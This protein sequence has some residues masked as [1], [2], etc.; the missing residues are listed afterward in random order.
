[1]RGVVAVNPYDYDCGRGL[2]RSSVLANLFIGMSGLPLISGAI[3]RV[4]PYTAV[5]RILQG[6]VYR[7]TAS[8]PALLREL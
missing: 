8:P 7:R 5:K 6:G 1:V 2:R 3:G 4:Q